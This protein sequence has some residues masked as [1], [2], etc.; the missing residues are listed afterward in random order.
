MKQSYTKTS[1]ALFIILSLSIGL[2]P[3]MYA[4]TGMSPIGL[5]ST[6]A[7]ELLISSS[8]SLLFTVHIITGGIA[9]TIGWMQFI[10]KW[11]NAH[12]DLHKLIGKIYLISILI[13]SLSSIYIAL[14]ATGGIISTLGFICLAIVWLIAGGMAYLAILKRKIAKHKNWMIRSYALTWAAVTLRL[15]LPIFGL[16]FG[17]QNFENY[18]QAVA[19]TCWIPNLL[20]V[21]YFISRNAPSL[22]S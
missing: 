6:K 12:K 3:V 21:N 22:S 14:F 17:F 15:Q 20:V 13:S 5:L 18:Y 1:W 19:W 16:I 2:Y 10:K 9:L 4:F 7:P 8:Y 11:R